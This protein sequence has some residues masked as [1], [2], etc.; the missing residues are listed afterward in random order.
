MAPA[1][2]RHSFSRHLAKKK[3]GSS[4][5]GAPAANSQLKS[6]LF[7]ARLKPMP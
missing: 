7:E 6:V 4:R 1:V 3:D 5:C 2:S